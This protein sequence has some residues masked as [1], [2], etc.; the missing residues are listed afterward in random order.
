[1]KKK[2]RRD[3]EAFS[4]SFLDAICCGFGAIVLLLVLSKTAEPFILEETTQELE[5]LIANLQ[6]QLYEIRGETTVMN[7]TMGTRKHQ[8]GAEK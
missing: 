6:E 7:R 8:L 4:M 5:A 3:V 2:G 1:M